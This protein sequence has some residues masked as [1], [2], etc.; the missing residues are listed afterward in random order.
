MLGTELQQRIAELTCA[1]DIFLGVF[2]ADEFATRL[3]TAV[4]GSFCIVNTDRSNQ[5]GTHWYAIFKVSDK[6]YETFDSLGQDEATARAHVG[7]VTECFFNSSRVQKDSSTSCGMFSAYFCVTRVLNYDE[8]FASVF[9]DSFTSDLDRNED[10]VNRFWKTDKL[11]SHIEEAE[12]F[13]FRG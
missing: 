2:A 1:K 6:L 9:A 8:T 12:T 3:R 10:I 11:Y 5:A 7:Q 13:V 4:A